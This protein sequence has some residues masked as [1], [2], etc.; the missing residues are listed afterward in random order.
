MLPAGGVF[1]G[2][3]LRG[4]L[5]GFGG[6]GSFGSLRLLFPFQ[7]LEI[8]YEDRVQNRNHQQRN[9][10]CDRQPADLRKAQWLPERTTMHREREKRQH[11][12]T[13]CNY[14]GPQPENA[15]INYRFFKKAHL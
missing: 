15:G 5:N 11:R 10:R 4:S 2:P 6:S 3:G 12:R 7:N 8:E 14:H 13:D 9:E 1:R